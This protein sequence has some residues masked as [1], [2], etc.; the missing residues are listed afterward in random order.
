MSVIYLFFFYLCMNHFLWCSFLGTTASKIYLT[1]TEVR[2][3]FN[4]SADVLSVTVLDLSLGCQ[5]DNLSVSLFGFRKSENQIESGSPSLPH[6]HISKNVDLFPRKK[7]NNPKPSA[8]FFSA[9][10]CLL[11]HSFFSPSLFSFSLRHQLFYL[12]SGEIPLRVLR[13]TS[14]G[15]SLLYS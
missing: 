7:K 6:L 2:C 14:K 11:K 13:R 15:K 8:F 3:R 5:L 12:S 9:S 4:A 10:L 1:A